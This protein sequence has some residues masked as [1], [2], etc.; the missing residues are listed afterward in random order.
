MEILIISVSPPRPAPC[1]CWMRPSKWPRLWKRTTRVGCT[2]PPLMTLSSGKLEPPHSDLPCVASAPALS[3]T[4]NVC[5][6]EHTNAQMYTSAMRG[7]QMQRLGEISS[8]G[9]D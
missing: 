9:G 5:R 2:F 7:P 6:R 8:S 1:R 3:G 4:P